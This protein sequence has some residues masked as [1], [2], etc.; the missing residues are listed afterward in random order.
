[1]G[2]GLIVSFLCYHKSFLLNNSSYFLKDKSIPTKVKVL[3]VSFS[4]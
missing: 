3:W 4:F 2:K 1:M